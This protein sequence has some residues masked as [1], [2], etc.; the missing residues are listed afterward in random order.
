MAEKKKGFMSR[1]FGGKSHDPV[2]E[3]T[4]DKARDPDASPNPAIPEGKAP[5][6]G[7]GGDRERAAANAEEDSEAGDARF[8]NQVPEEEG[9]VADEDEE[10]RQTTPAEEK[11]APAPEAERPPAPQTPEEPPRKRGFF[12]RLTEGLSRTSTKLTTGVTD[13]FTKKKLDEDTL[14]ELEDLLLS[15]DLGT[16]PTE[17]VVGRLRRERVGQDVTD[18]EV[19]AILAEVVADTLRPLEKPLAVNPSHAPHV[20]LVV[21]VNGAGK[22]TTIGKLASKMKA[23]GH[24]VLLAAGDTFRAAA[25]EQLAVWGERAN[26]PVLTKPNGADAAG[27][28]YE[29]IEKARTE[30]HDVVLIDTAGRLQNRSELMDE[31]GKIVRVIKKLAPEAPHDTL[32]VLDATVGQNAISQASAFT[33]IAGVTGLVMTKLDGTARGGILVALGDKF[34]L[35]IH[36]IGV[37]EGIDDLRPFDAGEFARALTADV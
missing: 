27:L 16:G 15:A 21:G 31:L 14:E 26:V 34:E 35:P 7:R 30:G 23:E 19:K 8:L 10:P 11:R 24:S 37:G 17:E 3:P 4:Y 13:I 6:L 1:L 28:A 29:A 9:G 5:D 2:D 22:T 32:L 36:Y 18:E 12:G 25:I 33:E 20:I